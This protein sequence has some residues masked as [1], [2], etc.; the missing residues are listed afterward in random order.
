[1]IFQTLDDK[2]DCVGIYYN[3]ELHFDL[4]SLPAGLTKTWKYVSYLRDYGEIDYAEIYLEGRKPSEVLPEYLKE[5]WEDVS[6]KL[7][8]VTRSL[9]L[10][11]V[12]LDENCIYDLTPTR[13]LI[14]TCEIKNRMTEYIIKNLGKPQRYSYLLKV[15]QMLDDIAERPLKINRKV[16]N[17][18]MSAA[19]SKTQYHKLASASPKIFY[20]QF[21]TK[22]G[23]LTT[24]PDSFPLL[25]L[26][27][28]LRRIIE[29]RNDLFVEFDFNGAEVRV[30]LGLLGKEQP[31]GD[32]HD[33][34]N[35]E[36]FGNHYT[37]EEVKTAF[38]AWLYGSKSKK[39]KE[40]GK[41][42][43]TFYNKEKILG[44]YWDG[45]TVR[46]PLKKHIPDVDEHHA[47]NYIVQST[48]AELTLLQ[49]LKIDYFLRSR[50][51][52]SRIAAIIHDSVIIDFCKDETHIIPEIFKLMSSTMFGTFGVNVSRG[53]NLGA[54]RKE[55]E[56]A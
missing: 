33:F 41:V 27:K 40:Y 55:S 16:L 30:M 15:R 20:N 35:A 39:I 53:P 1:M 13:F 9:R 7:T 50:K 5:D 3:K 51:Y 21:G 23:R 52:R 24:T 28:S 18:Y 4:A 29:P 25:T 54:L 45:T 44:K 26:K 49:A 32:V 22:T 6:Q 46:T 38:F 34:H 47:L 19:S 56:Y 36:V 48:C 42:L 37:R 10:S 11:K 12:N 2:S 14:E 31:S 8:A 43:E 17:S